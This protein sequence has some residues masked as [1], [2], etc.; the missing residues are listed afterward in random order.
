MSS[1]GSVWED[2]GTYSGSNG[3]TYQR[4]IASLENFV[5]EDSV[6]FRFR[7]VTDDSRRANGW[8]IDDVSI[9]T[10]TTITGDAEEEKTNLPITYTLHQNYPN[11]FNPTTTIKY[12]L[13]QSA[14]VNLV[15]YDINGRDFW[16]HSESMQ[17][18]GWHQIQWNGR[19][20]SGQLVSTGVYLYRLQAG[21]F[22][23]VKKMVLMK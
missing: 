18:A 11:P 17:P 19:S 3:G 13:P 4:E 7:L 6:R 1:D 20:S 9:L 2:I 22:V 5:G 14:P 21:E 23:D 8:Y 12:G 16:Q 15:I 10:D